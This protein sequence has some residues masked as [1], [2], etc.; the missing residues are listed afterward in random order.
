MTGVDHLFEALADGTRRAAVEALIERPLTSGDLARTIGVTPQALTRHLRVLRR[1]GLVRADGDETDAR[2]RIY[3]V[4]PEA[5]ATLRSWLD[6]AE[7]LWSV[8]L[9]AFADFVKDRG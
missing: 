9:A 6:D 7:R 2:L 4:A 1:S 8:Q 3:R 5:F